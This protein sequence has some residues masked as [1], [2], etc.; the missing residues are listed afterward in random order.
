MRTISATIEIDASPHAVW[1]TL[2]DL[3]GY[4]SWNPFLRKAAGQVTVGQRLT[5]QAH[6]VNGRPM[7]FR[8]RVLAVTPAREWRW[9]GR[10]LAP[11]L[12]DGEHSFTLSPTP[13]GGTRLVQAEQFTGVFVPFTRQLINHTEAGFTA[14]NEA[15]KKHL[16][17]D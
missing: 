13:A 16:E 12:F 11:G 15:L 9:I 1:Q 3:A 8:P 5:L 6:P 4:P 7:T 10:L 17:A 14:M 2:T